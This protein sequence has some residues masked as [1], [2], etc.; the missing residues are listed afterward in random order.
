MV[1]QPRTRVA[2]GTILNITVHAEQPLEG[3]G[4]ENA[5]AQEQSKPDHVIMV[6]QNRQDQRKHQRTGIGEDGVC[7]HSFEGVVQI[8]VE[9]NVVIEADQQCIENK[10]YSHGTYISFQ[11]AAEQWSLHSPKRGEHR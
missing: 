9:N 8:L 1:E 7:E 4:N 5:E 10:I 11:P 3:I 6:Q 2:V